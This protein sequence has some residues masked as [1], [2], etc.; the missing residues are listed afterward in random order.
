MSLITPII[1]LTTDFGEKDYFVGSL[2]GVIYGINP[3]VRIVDISHGISS[4]DI[5]EAAFVI[6]SVYKYF[7]RYTIHIIV[8]D[9]G[10]GSKRRP[11]VVR[12]DNY[13]FLAPDN[14]ILSY[15][16]KEDG[17][18]MAREL[19][20]EHYFLKKE[21]S[22]FHGRDIF[23]P[24]AAWLSK[25]VDTKNFGDQFDNYV[26]LNLCEPKAIGK[27]QIAGN[28]IHIDK[29]GNLI[30]NITKD[31]L[32]TFGDPNIEDKSVI[33]INDVTINGLK[34]Y[35]S[36]GEKGKA[37]ALINSCDHLE[38]YSYTDSAKNLLKANR[39]DDCILTIRNRSGA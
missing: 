23:A 35:Y 39:Y 29:F 27:D 31:H 10:V 15:I 3:N 19:T 22:T 21:G 16:Y 36:Q 38:I 2:K 14:G 6:K 13:Y 24:V 26:T 37:N 20:A 5:E 28:I 4:Q 34:K 25:G 33:T 7:P 9:P 30:T 11:I 1:T 8:V 12:S 32:E 18:I 17:P